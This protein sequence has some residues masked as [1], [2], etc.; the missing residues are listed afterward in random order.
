MKSN[1]IVPFFFGTGGIVGENCEN[2][3]GIG[4]ELEVRNENR[5]RET[6][7]KKGMPVQIIKRPGNELTVEYDKE[8]ILTVNALHKRQN[9]DPAS[10]TSGADSAGNRRSAADHRYADIVPGN[11]YHRGSF[12]WYVKLIQHTKRGRKK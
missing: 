3:G 6:E 10:G 12:V 7:K 4:M 2:K 1:F 9:L 5:Q 8:Q 11:L